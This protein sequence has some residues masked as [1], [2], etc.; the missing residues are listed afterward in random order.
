MELLFSLI[1]S[2][3]PLVVLGLIIWAIVSFARR[4]REEEADPG[5]GTV[6]RLFIYGGAVKSLRWFKL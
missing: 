4:G 2:F 1:S 5:I 3:V 6:R